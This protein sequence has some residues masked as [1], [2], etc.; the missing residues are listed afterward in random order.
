MEKIIKERVSLD[1][2]MI[3]EDCGHKHLTRLRQCPWCLYDRFKNPDDR[4]GYYECY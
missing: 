4:Q 3:C 1:K 2:V